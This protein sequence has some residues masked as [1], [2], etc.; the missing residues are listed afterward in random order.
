MFGYTI[1]LGGLI[2]YKIGLEQAQ[3]AYIKLTADENSTFNRFRRSLWAKIG[4][5]VLVVF[6]VLAMA[7]GFTR[8][9]ID[10]A[11]TKTGLTGVPEPEMVD[12]YSGEG[13]RTDDTVGGWDDS[14]SSGMHYAS[15]IVPT[16]PLDVVIY[17]PSTSSENT[18]LDTFQHVLSLPMISALNP[19][20]IVY[21]D[22]HIS[23]IQVSQFVP[24]GQIR[25]ASAAYLH[26][27]RGHYDML[28]EQT[29]FL[30]TDV[31]AQQ[32]MSTVESRY[33]PRTGVVELSQGGYGVCACVECVDVF[34]Q[35]RT[36]LSKVDELYA[37]T[38]ENICST[39]EQLLVLCLEYAILTFS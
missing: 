9:G 31:D 8:G 20:V 24:L 2:W 30:H 10:T 11:A 36:H 13:V 37:L 29:M 35:Q 28:A 3:A 4:A 23:T 14:G 1:A 17:V 32:V 39:T 7:H 27:I 26:Y 21:A 16:H 12:A 6:V 22:S 38:N 33:S 34:Q 5:G 19:H 15:D 18:T 25:S